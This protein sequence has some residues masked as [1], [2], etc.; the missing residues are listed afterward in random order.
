MHNIPG[1]VC[2]VFV[3]NGSLGLDAGFRDLCSFF[4]WSPLLSCCRP[5]LLMGKMVTV[6]VKEM[7]VAVVVPVVVGT[8][9]AVI[10]MVVFLMLVMLMLQDSG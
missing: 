10:I 3:Q 8:V 6:V 2:V 4:V 9:T 7:M 1:R 5:L